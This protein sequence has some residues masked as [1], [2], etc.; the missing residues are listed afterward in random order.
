MS[1]FRSLSTFL[2][3]VF[4][5]NAFNL[6][7]GIDGL[8]AGLSILSSLVFGS[9]FLINGHLSY[10]IIS[11]SLTGSILG[12]FYYNVYG[13]TNRLFM[14]DTGSLVIGTVMSV[15]FIKFNEFNIDQSLPYSINFGLF[16]QK[17]YIYSRSNYYAIYN[18]GFSL[19]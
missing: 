15:I 4:I 18:S 9:W 7:D 1:S 5:I 17:C 11:F 2:A 6:M 12:F 19:Q 8:A 16:A 10:A 13:K 3:I 14:G